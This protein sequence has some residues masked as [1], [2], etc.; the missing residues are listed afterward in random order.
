MAHNRSVFF[1]FK[2][3]REEET[4]NTF[5]TFSNPLV[6][7]P[8][9]PPPPYTIDYQNGLQQIS[10]QL[11]PKYQCPHNKILHVPS[12]LEHATPTPFISS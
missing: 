1:C 12:P 3:L 4:S 8:A 2:I 9:Q 6:H 7:R 5:K 10:P 11:F